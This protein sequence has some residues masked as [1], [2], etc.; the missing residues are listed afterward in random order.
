MFTVAHPA[1]M[2]PPCAVLSP[3][4]AAGMPPINTEAEPAAM[5]S[6]GPVQV[7][8]SPTLAAGMPPIITVGA[9]GGITGPPT[10]GT[11]PVVIGHT[12]IS[13]TL[14]ANGILIKFILFVFSF[15]MAIHL[16]LRRTL[17]RCVLYASFLNLHWPYHFIPAAK[18]EI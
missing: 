6:S 13:P 9:P 8:I 16:L 18:A 4:L 12:C 15:C 10:C 2:V 17:V 14:A 1:T 5:V 3:N 7:S 11:T